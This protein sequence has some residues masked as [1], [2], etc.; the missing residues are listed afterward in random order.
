MSWTEIKAAINSTLGKPNFTAVDEIVKKMS[1]TEIF[2][3]STTAYYLNAKGATAVI[4][5]GQGQKSIAKE[6][7]K[8]GTAARV[9]VSPAVRE[10]KESAFAQSEVE[11]I[12]IPS[13]VEEI[14]SAAFKACESL[15][16]VTLPEKIAA[17]RN[18]IFSGCSALENVTVKDCVTEIESSA[19]ENCTSLKNVILPKAVKSI[20]GTAFT[21]CSGVS[22]YAG[23]ND[24]EV[25]NAPW[26]ATQATVYYGDGTVKEYGES[27]VSTYKYAKGQLSCVDGNRFNNYSEEAANVWEL[28]LT[29]RADD[30]A[31]EKI[32]AKNM[33]G[34]VGWKVS[35]TTDGKI[36]YYTYYNKSN[37]HVFTQTVTAGTWNTLKMSGQYGTSGTA[38][39][40]VT[41]VVNGE[42]ET[43]TGLAQTSCTRTARNLVIG[44]EKISLKGAIKVKGSYYASATKTTYHTLDVNVSDA[45][46]GEELSLTN[47][48]TLTGGTVYEEEE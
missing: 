27:A 2:E 35:L 18:S 34:N 24:G 9:I 28:E 17:V 30:L 15:K 25:D 8:S 42:S 22:I 1:D 13:T 44:G 12:Y 14:R 5:A 48:Y 36:S 21:G 38:S 40:R 37:T 19:F 46:V 32:L 3:V 10:I 33:S 29:F 45:T 47:T 11:S 4:F 6:Q 20:D 43:A 7:Y 39:G 16:S 41:A 31:E 26:G 23:F